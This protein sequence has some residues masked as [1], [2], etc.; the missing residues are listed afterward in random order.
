M[1]QVLYVAGALACFGLGYLLKSMMDRRTL[2][3]AEETKEKA[4]REAQT[5]LKE[6]EVS[7]KEE[8]LQK[9]DEFD[10]STKQ[11]RQEL[12]QLEK[13]L[14]NREK[15]L[16]RRGEHLDSRENELQKREKKVE[17]KKEET[18]K[19][20]EKLD[21]L[22]SKEVSE[23]ERIA[24]LSREDARNQLLERL[25]QQLEGEQGEMIR[26]FHEEARQ[27]CEREAQEIM[28][29]AMQR[30]ANDCASERTTA[31]VPLPNDE[32][33]GRVIGREGRNI[34]TIEATAGVSVL[35]DDTPEAVVISCFDPVRKEIARI[36]LE[37]LV[38][39]GR[40]H[41][42]R[43]EEMVAKVTEEMDEQINKI[44]Q[45]TIEE[46]HLTGI[47]PNVIKMLGRLKY[48]YSYTQN[49]LQH[50]K[51]VA[52]LMGSIAAQVGL[53]EYKAKRVGLLHDIGKAVDHEVEGTHAQIAADV[54]KRAGEDDEVINAVAAHHEEEEAQTPLAVL[55]EVCDTLSASRPGARSEST[56]LYL[57]RIEDL[58]TIGNSYPGVDYCYAIQAGRELR[59]IVKAEEVDENKAWNLARNI[60]NQ[61]ESEMRYP[62]NVKVTVVRETRAVDYAK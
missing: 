40:I 43:V 8:I 20:S 35:I 44:G 6:A 60:S 4:E 9:R 57:K 29:N 62:G 28:I 7:A 53:D 45:E 12:E 59:V 55:A 24:S 14:D 16:D 2:K 48:R 18:N 42:T 10:K 5:I 15:E 25:G 58:E 34:R 3:S 52:Y 17:E 31:T 33:K 49:V 11:R 30:Y 22:I 27:R 51:E 23:L 38:A 54:L 46:M 50:S 1:P 39:D 13:E 21:Q 41:P 61:V 26:R 47:K 56:E 36:A 32:M 19:Q 37:R